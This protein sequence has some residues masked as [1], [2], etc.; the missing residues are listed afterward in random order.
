MGEE[1]R[2]A[3]QRF[4]EEAFN[5]GNIRILPELI[6]PE[7]ISHLPTGDHYGPEGVRIDIAGFRA[8]FPDLKLV[9]DD[10]IETSETVVYRFTA[11]GTHDGPF[12][13]V[14][15]TGRRVRV[16]GIGID[17]FCDGKM[18]ERWV[19]YDRVGLLQQLGAFPGFC[20][21]AE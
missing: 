15:P 6:A 20:A 21:C 13:G 5:A 14:A 8:A 7:H 12:M 1:Q 9:L 2:L 3:V 11:R 17:R 10:V 18:V 4:F 16:D 19:Q